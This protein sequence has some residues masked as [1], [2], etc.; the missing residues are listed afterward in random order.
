MYLVNMVLLTEPPCVLPVASL[1]PVDMGGKGEVWGCRGWLM[2]GGGGLLR[3][4]GVCVCVCV[5][6]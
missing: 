5:C 6:V 3:L 4:G 2:L 1:V